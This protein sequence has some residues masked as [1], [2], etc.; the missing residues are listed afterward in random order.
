MPQVILKHM[1]PAVNDGWAYV[2]EAMLQNLREEKDFSPRARAYREMRTKYWAHEP[3][4][5]WTFNW[6]RAKCLYAMNPADGNIWRQL[7]SPFSAAVF[8]LKLYP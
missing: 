1:G 6:L 4:N 5:V 3:R 8:L 2:Q 7:T